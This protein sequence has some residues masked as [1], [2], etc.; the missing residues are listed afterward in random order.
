M[1]SAD[2][3]NSTESTPDPVSTM[4]VAEPPV[5]SKLSLPSPP[6]SE[7]AA[8]PPA[9]EIRSSPTPARSVLVIAVP[10]T[11]MESLPLPACHRGQGHAANLQRVGAITGKN[12]GAFDST[13]NRQAVSTI[14]SI[15]IPLGCCT[16]PSK[17]RHQQH[18][19]KKTCQTSPKL[20]KSLPTPPS[21]SAE[22]DAPATT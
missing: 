18:P 10:A 8:T 17:C 20:R 14:A 3:P 22:V 2:P 9:I 15:G 12:G 11:T 5:K 1:E 16:P 13:S 19:A 4:P 6:N 21:I 7:P